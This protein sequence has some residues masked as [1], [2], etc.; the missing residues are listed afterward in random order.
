ME[1]L[2][3]APGKLVWLGEYAVLERAPALVTA[4]NR[5]ARVRLASAQGKT[6]RAT[7]PVRHST[8]NESAPHHSGRTMLRALASRLDGAAGAAAA[9]RCVEVDTE[10]LYFRGSEGPLKLGLGSSAA[11]VVA[12]AGALCALSGRAPPDVDALIRIHRQGQMGRGSGADVAAAFH[13]GVSI[14]C[15]DGEASRCESV[16]LPAELRWCCVW[17]GRPAS[18]GDLLARMAAWREASPG[19]YGAAMTALR[20][21]ADAG[22]AAVVQG[23]AAPLLDAVREYG[24]QLA[25]LGTASGVEI[26]CSEHRAIGAIATACGVAYKSC[27]AGGGDVGVALTTDPGA[28]AEFRRRATRDGWSLLDLATDSQGLETRVHA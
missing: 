24:R 27:G 2:A 14:Y 28:L 4:V 15:W 1:V 9:A 7:N 8:G 10:A 16:A 13:G 21:A 6:D 12:M 3:S 11:L 20:V 25:R 17:S 5:R 26:V 19:R 23:A 22:A 18:T